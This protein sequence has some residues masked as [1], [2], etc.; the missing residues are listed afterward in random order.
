MSSSFV[1]NKAFYSVF[2]AQMRVTAGFY[3]HKLSKFAWYFSLPGRGGGAFAPAEPHW[4]PGYA[5]CH[6]SYESA[7]VIRYVV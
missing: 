7:L 3:T 2:L 1:L 4:G 6:M 5:C